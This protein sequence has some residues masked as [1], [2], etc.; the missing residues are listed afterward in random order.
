MRS[1]HPQ[2]KK[3]AKEREK[4]GWKGGKISRAREIYTAY[5]VIASSAARATVGSGGKS[6]VKLEGEVE[7]EARR[8]YIR[9]KGWHA[10]RAGGGANRNERREMEVGGRGR[11][12]EGGL[13]LERR[14]KFGAETRRRQHIVGLLL[15][16]VEAPKVIATR[17]AR[18]GS[19]SNSDWHRW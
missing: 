1:A 17:T 11:G 16:N 15:V 6:W 2:G 3:R 14:G 5:V 4:G 9:R 13:D 10:F 12:E 19:S 18:G 8:I 7:K